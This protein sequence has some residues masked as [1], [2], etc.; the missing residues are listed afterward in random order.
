M[1]YLTLS[2][3]TSSAIFLLFKWF[4]EKNINTFQAIV[5]NYL[6]ASALG[7]F[8]SFGKIDYGNILSNPVFRNGALLGFLFIGLFF[9][10]ALISQKMGAGISSTATK[11]SLVIPT[12]FF[13]IINPN[14][15]WTFLKVLALILSIPGVILTVYQPSSE[16]TIKL[17]LPFLLFLGSGL[18]DITLAYTEQ[19]FAHTDTDKILLTFSPFMVSAVNT[20]RFTKKSILYGAILGLINFGSI[21]Y[22][23]KTFEMMNLQKSQIIPINNLG[24]V[25]VSALAAFILLKER[26]NKFNKLGLIISIISILVLIIDSFQA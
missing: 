9:L 7:I 17:F 2:L 13:I 14:E 18:L 6:V 15:P 23:L 16:R 20:L 26:L 4:G 11:L 21:Y 8:L 3:L 22:L 25:V 10:M 24:I 19:E 1:I 5:I 12:L